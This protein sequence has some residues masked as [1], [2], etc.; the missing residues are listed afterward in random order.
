MFKDYILVGVCL[1]RKGGQ[2]RERG[3]I[4]ILLGRV[5]FYVS[6]GQRGIECTHIQIQCRLKQSTQKVI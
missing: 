6:A 4:A 1:C 3:A 5:V 2:L